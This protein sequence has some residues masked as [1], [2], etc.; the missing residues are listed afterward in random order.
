MQYLC[1][2]CD[3]SFSSQDIQCPS[4]GYIWLVPCSSC[5]KPNIRAAK[6]CGRCGESM[7]RVS[8]I[9]N[10]ICRHFSRPFGYNARQIGTGFAFGG[11]LAFFAFGSLGMTSPNHRAI[12][13]AE[14]MAGVSQPGVA[15]Q[16]SGV[17]CLT[18]L[19]DW[20]NDAGEATREAS[21]KDLMQVGR[22]VLD[23][24]SE[25]G[26]D[27]SPADSSKDADKIRYLQGLRSGLSAEEGK[28][29]RRGDVALFFYRIAGSNL[30]V[31]LRAFPETT[32]SDIPRHHYMTVPVRTLESLGVRI[33]RNDA[34]FGSDDAM[35]VGS[36]G[37]IAADFLSQAKLLRK[38][39][40]EKKNTR[41]RP[42][43]KAKP[44]TA[45]SAPILLHHELHENGTCKCGALLN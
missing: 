26:T 5:G 8:R 19:R 15:D 6:F 25:D 32:Y 9:W 3:A 39:D 38:S 41:Q 11:L 31:S 13:P 20:R 27:G 21:L 24:L 45:K 7:S 1:P 43:R 2:R 36:L 10:R 22:K 14:G 35:T 40:D 37:K 17:D 33:A 16:V 29:L 18:G 28:P 34:V 42:S 44:Q 30:N 23:G 12:A 4:C